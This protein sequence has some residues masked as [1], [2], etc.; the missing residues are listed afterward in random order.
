MTEA[1]IDK[2]FADLTEHAQQVLQPVNL[3]E[4]DG[5]LLTLG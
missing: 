5:A 2:I 3:A 1:D 4:T